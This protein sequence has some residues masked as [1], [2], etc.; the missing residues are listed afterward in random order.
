MYTHNFF[1]RSMRG[2]TLIE[3][4]VVITI[5]GVFLSVAIPQFSNLLVSMRLTSQINELTADIR[6]A[7]SEAGA[8]GRRVVICPTTDG[9]ASCS[10]T[11]S[12]WR[13]GRV[14]FVDADLDGDIQSTETTLKF[15]QGLSGDSNVTLSSF[16]SVALGFN[17]YGGLLQGNALGGSGSIKICSASS[18]SGRQVRIDATGRPAASRITC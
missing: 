16:T 17:P 6:F 12:D 2:V 1:N 9:G 3:L 13:L 10:T 4:L 18:T 11:A 7:R 14:V 15:T 8:R 5:V